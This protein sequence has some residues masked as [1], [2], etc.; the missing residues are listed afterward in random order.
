MRR[1]VWIGILAL[2]GCNKPTEGV[3]ADPALQTLVPA[4][5]VLMVGTR[6]EALRKTPVY[7]KYLS[8]RQ[9]PQIEEFSQRTGLDPR[10]DLWELLFVSNGKQGV[11]LGRGKFANEM[12]PRLE[13]EGAQRFGYKG[14]N[15]IGNDRG[16]VVFINSST[17]A[18]GEID[19]LHSLIDQRETSHGP[20]PAL[21]AMMKEIPAEAQFWAAYSG[22]SIKLPFDENSNLANMNKLVSYVQAG[23]LYFDL[24]TGLNGMAQGRCSSEAGAQQVHDAL[25][26]IVGLGRLSTPKEQPELLQVYDSIRVTQESRRVRLH[27]DVRQELAD[28]FLGV[29]M[30]SSARPDRVQ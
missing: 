21:A 29:W 5:T 30:G 1:F 13:E 22:G 25:K 12:E 15:L 24:R 2:A 4:D 3:K 20:P 7:Q 17:A 19:A 9:F 27:I 14:F 10:R 11:L 26:A 6:L 23:T 28:R 8:G 16:A 18:I